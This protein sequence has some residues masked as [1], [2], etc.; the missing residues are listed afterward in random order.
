MATDQPA[1]VFDR[2]FS[3]VVGASE[4]VA[5]GIARVT[6]P[7]ASDYTFTGTNSFIVGD[8][9]VFLVDAGPDDPAHLEALVAAVGKRRVEAVLLTHTHKDHS[10]GA[11]AAAARFSAPVWFAGQHRR[12]RPLRPFETDPLAR[13]CDWTLV[14]DR[15]LSDGEVLDAGGMAIE[16]ITTPGH[17]AN[18]IAFG[19]AGTPY[20]LSGD[21][22]MGWNSTLVAVPD[23]S[24]R[25]YLASLDKL[26]I[27]DFATYLPAHG[28][29][30]ADGPGQARALARHRGRRNDQIVEFASHGPKTM[31][32]L[33]EAIYPGMPGR[34]RFAA[35]LTLAA[36]VEYLAEVQ[37]LRRRFGLRGWEV[38]AG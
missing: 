9:T 29:P 2:A 36:H 1:L 14:P 26:V 16:V 19:I 13:A 6:A 27:R 5:D 17:C 15:V 32:D 28:G 11:R 38:V 24:M 23:G 31:R 18:H 10:A 37:G 33:L 35:R 7:N 25:D 22:V 21:H 3:P 20:L 34:S 30:V 4:P 8:Q 12:S